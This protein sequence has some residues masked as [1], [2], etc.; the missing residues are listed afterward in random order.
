[1]SSG[2]VLA[3]EDVWSIHDPKAKGNVPGLL[4][5]PGLILALMLAVF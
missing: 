3:K 5:T 1:V 2:E 4:H